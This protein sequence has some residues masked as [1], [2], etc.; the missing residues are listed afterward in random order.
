MTIRIMEIGSDVEAHAR[1]ARLLLD[2]VV[3]QA[4]QV[5]IGWSEEA[6]RTDASPS[7]GPGRRGS[8]VARRAHHLATWAGRG[9]LCVA[10]CR[11]QAEPAEVSGR[12]LR[13]LAD[14]GG[15]QARVELESG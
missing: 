13:R 2:A 6:Q 14:T 15:P 3:R 12:P 5:R 9:G 7:S 8:F 11:F 10:G 4:L 1:P